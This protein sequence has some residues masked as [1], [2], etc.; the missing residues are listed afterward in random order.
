MPTVSLLPMIVLLAV[1]WRLTRGH[2][3]SIAVFSA[4]FSAASVM[5]IAGRGVAPWTFALAA[6]MIVKLAQGQP[7]PKFPAGLNKPAIFLLLLFVV[8]ALGSAIV[9]PLAFQG[10]PVQH[11][12][13]FAPLTWSLSNLAQCI[14]LLA[15][16]LLYLVALTNTRSDLEKALVWYVRA[17][18]AESCL[19]FYQLAHAALHVPYPSAVFYSNPSYAIF[20]AYKIHGFWRLNGTFPEASEMAVYLS[21]G[22]ALRGWELFTKPLTAWRIVSLL[23]MVAAL[24]MSISSMGY[25]GLI[26]IVV[27]GGAAAFVSFAR[28]R[29]I[30]P[31]RLILALLLVAGCVG[32]YTFSKSGVETI[33]TVF[34][35]TLLEKTG[36]D[37]Y[38]ARTAT[39]GTAL[40]TLDKTDYLGAGWGSIRASGLVYVLLGTVGI[41]GTVLFLLF[42]LL[43]Y[44]PF[45][46]HHLIAPSRE[47]EDLQKDLFRRSLFAVTMLLA[48]EVVAGAEP[49]M[50]I[51]WVLLGVAT[52]ACKQRKVFPG[53]APGYSGVGQMS[54]GF[55]TVS[56]MEML[57][58]QPK[59]QN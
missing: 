14:Y 15:A 40:L 31:L 38:R 20:H 47:E 25:L 22:I 32:F 8:Y 26:L 28:R 6:G 37:S 57:R 59:P 46:Y 51:L 29:T 18:V 5:N 48:T 39:H 55:P 7:M 16:L 30:S 54:Y 12:T 56:E 43:L 41:P 36:T 33:T 19:A 35:S 44:R 50:P 21:V 11:D 4:I 10:V 58:R 24:L 45:L 17:C 49:V 42:Y 3:L 2:L 23:L 1:L 27:C 13:T 34:S 52:A 9:Y 53:I